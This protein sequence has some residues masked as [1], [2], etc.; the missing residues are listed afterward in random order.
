MN[1]YDKD[2]TYP[3]GH[4]KISSYSKDRFKTSSAVPNI[5]LNFSASTRISFQ[6]Y[7]SPFDGEVRLKWCSV[8]A[9]YICTTE[10]VWKIHYITVMVWIYWYN[11]LNFAVAC[12]DG[13]VHSEKYAGLCVTPEED[14]EG[15]LYHNDCGESYIMLISLC[16]MVIDLC[17]MMVVDK[18]IFI[19]SNDNYNIYT[20]G[21]QFVTS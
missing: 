18:V 12:P 9:S 16:K 5:S 7:S 17:G 15:K 8:K 14:C 1:R 10:L 4:W 2:H 20:K 11:G 21:L 3:S 6:W 19:Q 13:R